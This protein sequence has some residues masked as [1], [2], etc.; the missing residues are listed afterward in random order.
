MSTI[1]AAITP[2]DNLRQGFKDVFSQLASGVSVVTFWRGNHLHGFTAT[3]L[4]SV[5]LQPPRVLF[6]VAQGSQSYAALGAGTCVGISLLSAGQ[7][8]LSD[9]FA[10]KL[11]PGAYE[12][13]AL[14]GPDERA[15]L[16]AG[17][18]G[19]LTADIVEL[20]PSG[21]HAIVLCDVTAA[22]AAGGAPLLYHAR[23]YH[24]LHPRS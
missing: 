6:C 2:A 8:E 1:E 4:T 12:D 18:L 3:S 15:P 16:I 10:R 5:S 20:I 19:H 24:T 14:T 9:R 11:A 23:A 22:Q 7:R 13:V 17:A 21:D